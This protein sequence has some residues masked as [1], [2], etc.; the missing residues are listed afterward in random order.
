MDRSIIEGQRTRH[1]Y[2]AVIQP[3]LPFDSHCCR[4]TPVCYDV[5]RGIDRK[6]GPAEDLDRKKN[7]GDFEKAW[8]CLRLNL[9]SCSDTP[10]Y[11]QGQMPMPLEFNRP[12]GCS[13]PG[14]KFND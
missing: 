6:Y 14:P 2:N 7:E 10:A 3:N 5:L 12:P 1:T 9:W 8:C 11:V 4:L 13:N